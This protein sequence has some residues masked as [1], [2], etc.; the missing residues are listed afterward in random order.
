VYCG[1]F[2]ALAVESS[3]IFIQS[4]H[5]LK[6][7]SGCPDTSEAW[8]FVLQPCSVLVA[9]KFCGLVVS[10]W[11]NAAMRWCASTACVS[12]PRNLSASTASRLRVVINFSISS[13]CCSL[14]ATFALR[15]FRSSNVLWTWQAR[16]THAPI[17]APV[18]GGPHFESRFDE[19][20]LL[21]L[22]T[23]LSTAV[24]FDVAQVWHCQLTNR[25]LE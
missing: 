15:C 21:L 17:T 9:D 23:M 5:E 22:C 6:D 7:D 10:C 16:V 3:F 25:C 2:R 1:N 11:S 14:I 12:G 13:L 20:S 18:N 24:D 8:P 19:M 4:V